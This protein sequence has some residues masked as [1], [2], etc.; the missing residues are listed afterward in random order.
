MKEKFPLP[1][2]ETEPNAEAAALTE[3]IEG[4]LGAIPEKYLNLMLKYEGASEKVKDEVKK[5]L[6]KR[7]K[8]E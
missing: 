4:F 1:S 8:S 6:V 3:I 2:K 7:K 5:E